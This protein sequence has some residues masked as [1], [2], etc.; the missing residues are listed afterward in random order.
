MYKNLSSLIG[1]CDEVI[2]FYENR[3]FDTESMKLLSG[4]LSQ[5]GF[6]PS[7]KEAIRR[8]PRNSYDHKRCSLDPYLAE[9]E[10]TDQLDS[11]DVDVEDSEVDMGVRSR[12]TSDAHESQDEYSNPKHKITSKPIPCATKSGEREREG[13][14]KM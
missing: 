3:K 1:K 4:A 6:N 9:D 12:R 8:T 10:S 7:E 13:E 14:G 2:S 11:F 5:M